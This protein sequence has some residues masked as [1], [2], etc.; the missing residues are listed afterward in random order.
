MLYFND[1]TNRRGIIQEI[2]RILY[3]NEYGRISGNAQLLTDF[4]AAINVARDDYTALLTRVGGL[5]A[6]EDFNYT[7][8]LP[9]IYFDLISG[10]RSYTL[11]QD[12]T[13]SNILDIYKLITYTASGV[14]SE[15]MPIEV[16]QDDM[17][18]S[19]MTIPDFYNG[20]KLYGT[21]QYYSRTANTITLDIIPNYT[22]NGAVT[23]IYG[24]AAYISREPTYYLSTDTTKL[25]GFPGLFDRYLALIPAQRYAMANGMANVN[26]ITQDRVKMEMD[27]TTYY[28]KRLRD[29]RIGL[30]PRQ[31][32]NH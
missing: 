8:T 28:G 29:A 15:L 12:G 11:L 7:N 10:Q 31:Q 18:G 23:G 6:P 24:L 13:G 5:S 25:S 26:I 16:R 4:T 19:A 1:V 27:I 9:I 14:G 20:T 17:M 32:N 22:T 30:T 3:P 21:S 2:E